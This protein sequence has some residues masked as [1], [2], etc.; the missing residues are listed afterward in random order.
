MYRGFEL[1]VFILHSL[2]LHIGLGFRVRV[3]VEVPLA[4]VIC[5]LYCI[6]AT[7]GLIALCKP[8]SEKDRKEMHVLCT[9]IKELDPEKNQ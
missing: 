3:R 5:V 9:Q 1:C 6:R 7:W 2:Y 8:V 4:S